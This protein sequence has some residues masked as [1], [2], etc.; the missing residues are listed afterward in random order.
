LSKRCLRIYPGFIAAS[1]FC[2]L[3]VGPLAGA[4]LA[5]LSATDW[6]NTLLRML[7]QKIPKLQGAFAGQHYPSL[8]GSMWTIVYEFRCYLVVPVMACFRLLNRKSA[9]PVAVA[10]WM[11]ALAT[12]P[13]WPQLPFEG[14]LGNL[15]EGMRLT[16]LFLTGAC[17]FLYRDRIAYTNSLAALAAIVLAIG[18]LGRSTAGPAVAILGGYIIFWFAF[19]PGTSTLNGIN[20]RTDLSYGIYL[21]AWP[22]QM[23]LIR[24]VGGISPERIIL[25]TT[26]IAG[27][28]AYLSWTFVERPFL[29]RKALLSPRNRAASSFRPSNQAISPTD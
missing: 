22:V 17:Y 26:I 20:S 11:A 2:I 13:D 16:A 23:L 9:L 25:F 18:L 6:M 19:L 24:Y 14:A 29:S 3:V 27:L 1:L 15:H 10:T 12:S 21:Y 28:L 8:N 5:T 7:A 4:N